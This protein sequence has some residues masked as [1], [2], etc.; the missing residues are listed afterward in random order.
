MSVDRR[1]PISRDPPEGGTRTKIG[2]VVPYSV[3]F[4]ISRDPPEGGTPVR[5]MSQS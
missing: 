1:F 5:A 2:P 4:P 3:L